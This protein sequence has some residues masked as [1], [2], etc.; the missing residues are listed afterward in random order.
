MVTMSRYPRRAVADPPRPF[1][2]ALRSAIEARGLTLERLQ[3]RLAQHGLT[4]SITSLSYWQHG[5]S[6][7]E[8]PESL[9]ALAVLESVLGAD[10]GSLAALLG[11][12]RRRGPRSLR[13]PRGHRPDEVFGPGASLGHLFDEIPGSRR[14]DLV[15]TN[16]HI[17]M[18]FD[19]NGCMGESTFRLLAEAQCDGA[20][21]YYAVYRGD[22][23]C[24]TAG[25]QIEA[26]SDCRIGRVAR[27]TDAGMLVAEVLFG[28]ELAAGDSQLFEFAIRDG[29]VVTSDFGH[30]FRHRIGQSL[31]QARFDAAALP[32]RVQSFTQDRLC[33]PRMYTGDLVLSPYRAVL[34][35]PGPALPSCVGL[36]WTYA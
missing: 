11:P 35:A 14:D 16:E 15:L 24:D 12:P 20:D 5:R 18:E 32:A 19:A 31:I 23:G 4:V 6:Q 1:H 26:L 9:R 13:G 3:D 22:A 33:D 10:P 25:L 36:T 30:A 29:S 8:R 21:R 27:D 7:P 28:A 2:I 34:L 17:R